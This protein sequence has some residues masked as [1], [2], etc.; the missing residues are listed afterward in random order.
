MA[1]FRKERN[2]LYI[3]LDNRTGDYRLDLSNGTFYGI[4]GNPVKTAPARELFELFR[5]V[6]NNGDHANLAYAL[7]EIFNFGGCSQTAKITS[8]LAILGGAEKLDAININRGRNFSTWDYEW[9]NEHMSDISKWLKANPNAPFPSSVREI[10]AWVVWE[11]ERKKL[12]A[13]FDLIT[14]AMYNEM[15]GYNWT[16]E[17]MSVGAYY[18]GRGK[19]W[20]Y[21]NHNLRYLNDY[22]FF[23]KEMNKK[24]EKVNNFMR[25]YV[26]TKK[27]YELRKVE[28]DMR[29]IAENYA[30]HSKAWEFEYGNYKIV[31]PT[32]PEDI[33][34]EGRNMSHCVGSYVNSVVN[35]ETYIVFVRPIANPEKCY[36][37]C[38]V[39]TNGRIGQ[40]FLSHDRYIS[41]D[42]DRE[43][44]NKF[45]EHLNAVW[46]DNN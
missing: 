29:K 19:Y 10:S 38:Q 23:C 18:L 1:T 20:E 33:I 25:E 40:Y 15:K 4:K 27:E 24:P 16:P 46:K 11:E 37:T 30:K 43:F 21:H 42:E 6:P 34:D 44:Y 3:T 13:E 26:E 9:A 7:A 36:I 35:N 14:P 31:V 12:G 2:N 45:Q 32:S 8:F 5:A 41:S 39:Y 22:F 28:I 17:Q